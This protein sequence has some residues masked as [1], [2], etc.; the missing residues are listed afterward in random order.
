[1]LSGLLGKRLVSTKLGGGGMQTGLQEL[2][3]MLVLNEYW[4]DAPLKKGMSFHCII[5]LVGT[6][7]E[8][9]QSYHHITKGK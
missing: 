4:Q 2:L 1:M 9:L 3:A 6:C 7:G 8:M 5:L